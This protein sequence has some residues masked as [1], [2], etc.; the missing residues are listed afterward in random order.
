V[1][2]QIVKA[3]QRISIVLLVASLLTLNGGNALAQNADGK[4]FAETGHWV[5]GD[6]WKFFQ[7]VSEPEFVFG[8]P[9]TEA[10]RDAKSGLLVQYFQRARFE[11][12]PGAA[13]GQTVQLSSLGSSLYRPGGLALNLNSLMACR[14]YSTT[15]YP[16]CYAFLDF[17][18]KYGGPGVF[19]YP[20]SGFE[21]YN[22]R[23]VQYFER[24]RFEWYPEMAEGQRVVLAN[25]GRIYFDSVPEDPQLLAPVLPDAIVGNTILTLQ[26]RVFTW[27]AVTL[28]NDQ[29]LIFI[30]LQ[31]QMLRPVSGA[32]GT[33]TVNW[34][35]GA[36][37]IAFTTD[38][39]GVAVIFLPVSNQPSGSLITITADVSYQ[40]LLGKAV[41]SFRVWK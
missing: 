17:Y 23:I 8:Y 21:I 26:P 36:Q 15:G 24:A 2:N 11:D 18:D 31:D 1:Y 25:L 29:Q 28:E 30:V 20:I 33:L 16:V 6:F 4:Y 10:F 12:H 41:T 14:V 3:L 7:S 35:T 37:S 32:T 27:K 40:D 38:Q 13:D 5:T 19:G 34:P 9:I 22:G 39:N